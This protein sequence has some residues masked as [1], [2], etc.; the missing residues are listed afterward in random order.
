[1]LQTLE[2]AAVSWALSRWRNRKLNIVSDSLYVVGVVQRIEDALVKPPNNARLCQLFLQVK[3][4]IKDREEPCCIIHIRSHQTELGLGEGNARAD[5][6]VSPAVTAPRD[7]FVAAR[8]SHALF[9]QAAKALKR[10][11]NI[12]QVDA[13]GIVRSCPQ[14][15]Q[16]GTS[17]GLDV[18]PRGLQACEIWQ[19]DVTHVPEF[20]RLKYVHVTVDTFSKMIWA[21]AQAGERAIHVIRHLMACFAVMGVPKQLKT[22]NGPAYVGARVSRLLQK[23]GVKHITGIPHVPTGQAIIERAHRTLK[24]YLQKQ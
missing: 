24:E 17:L 11:F 10:Q 5:A 21:T 15:S 18:N 12:S 3:R 9:H 8:E 16:H 22:D 7:S 6:L 20:G 13:Q 1:S 14:C 4:A 23:W 19:M 2:L